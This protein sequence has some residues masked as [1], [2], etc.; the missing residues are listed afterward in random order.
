MGVQLGTS[1]DSY[2]TLS[3]SLL[4]GMSSDSDIECDTET[5]EQEEHTSMGVFDDPFLAQPPDE[6]AA[7]SHFTQVP[8][9]LAA[10]AALSA[11]SAASAH[12]ALPLLLLFKNY[13]H[14]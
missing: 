2:H 6:G 7:C 12:S 11:S 3:P 9:S 13:C 4:P 10:A 1:V 14:L 8:K 5:E